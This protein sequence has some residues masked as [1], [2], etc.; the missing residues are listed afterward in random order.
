MKIQRQR[1]GK[2]K[3]AKVVRADKYGIFRG[4]VGTAYGNNKKGAARAMVGKQA[5]MAF[6]M[7]PVEDF[8]HPPFGGE[9]K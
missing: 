5:S 8:Y 1:D 3:L 4:K 6:A 7:K 2:W 9:V